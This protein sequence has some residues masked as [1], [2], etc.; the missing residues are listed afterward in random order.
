MKLIK[1]VV[2]TLMGIGV[3]C[4][5][6][7][8]EAYAYGGY[9]DTAI[10][11]VQSWYC[12]NSTMALYKKRLLTL[13][14]MIRNGASVDITLPETKGNTALHYA[15][16]M[17]Y[18]DLVQWLLNN[19]A[20]PYATTNRGMTPM[21]CVSNDPSGRIAA[22]LRQ[23]MGG[24]APAPAPRPSYHNDRSSLDPL[25]NRMAALRCRYETSALYQR[26][27]L[28]LLPMIRN[29]AHV[30]ITLPE[31]KGNTALHYSCAIGSLSITRW[32]LEHGANP[33]AV[34]HKGATPLMCVG[35][36]NGPA[37]RRLLRQYGAR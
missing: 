27:L 12:P 4:S 28:T 26:R 2:V 35:A 8:Q 29:G 21:Q 13:L 9:L 20:N 6:L 30:D 1:S 14:P 31:T 22:M 36:D 15:C 34:T 24:Y 10:Y 17:G 19:G 18:A 23:R 37:I 25:I 32:L 7:Q 3:V 33:N 16:G 5:S 11:T